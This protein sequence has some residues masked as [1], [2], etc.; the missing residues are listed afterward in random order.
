MV[1]GWAGPV[2]YEASVAAHAAGQLVDDLPRERTVGGLDE[3]A[4]RAA[5]CLAAWAPDEPLAETINAELDHVVG[6]RL[7]TYGTLRNE[8]RAARSSSRLGRRNQRCF[9]LWTSTANRFTT[10]GTAGQSHVLAVFA[11]R[12]RIGLMVSH[13]AGAARRADPACAGCQERPRLV[14]SHFSC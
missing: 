7:A 8:Y 10:Q 11:P 14:L 6:S 1:G 4:E 5:G 3:V 2:V 12:I 9:T 13:S